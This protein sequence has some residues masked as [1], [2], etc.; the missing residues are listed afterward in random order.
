MTHDHPFPSLLRAERARRSL[1]RAEA[2]E[3]LGVSVDTLRRYEQGETTPDVATLARLADA[4]A[5]DRGELLRL[6][7]E[8]A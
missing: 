7:V 2:A 4:Y 3:L 5:Q 8:G 1:T 6:I